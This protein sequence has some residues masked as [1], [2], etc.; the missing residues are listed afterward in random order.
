MRS[1]PAQAGEPVPWVLHGRRGGVY[2]RAGGGTQL[3]WTTHTRGSG[4]SPRRRGNRDVDPC[5]CGDQGS[6]PAQAGEPAALFG[7]THEYGVYP[8]AGGGTETIGRDVFGK[9][10]LSPRRRGNPFPISSRRFAMGSIPAQ[11]G[12]PSVNM[13]RCLPIRVYPRAGGGTKG[14]DKRLDPLPGLSPRRRGNH[15]NRKTS[16]GRVR[17]I[18]AQAGEPRR[19]VMVWGQ[20]GVYPRAGG[21]TVLCGFLRDPRAGLSPRR[22][23]NPTRDAGRRAVHGSIPAQAGE[24]R[25]SPWL[26]RLLRVYPRAGGGTAMPRS[27]SPSKAW[28][29]PAQAGEPPTWR[30][31]LES[32]AVY[33]R[34]GGGTA[35]CH[36]RAGCRSGLS[37]RRRG[38]HERRNHV[39]GRRG[40][41]PAQAGEPVS[42]LL[43]RPAARV[44][45][46]AG[47]GTAPP[48]THRRPSQGLSPRRRGNRT[49]CK[50]RWK[51]V[52]SIPAQAGEPDSRPRS[53]CL[54][55]VYP[56]AGGGTILDPRI[57]AA[58]SGLSPRRRGNP[59]L[60]SR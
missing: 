15:S 36:P 12:E 30:A 7:G 51:G 32:S 31:H 24:P 38:N 56:R 53:A 54:S 20:P 43:A 33:P 55:K 17:S 6:I 42:A 45:P 29:I 49:G 58:I 27:R 2:P 37:P 18:P 19:P 35:A 41:I 50:P 22:R 16:R 28:S 60:S 44:Y 5:P 11:A 34:A 57:S 46:R 26:L 3:T 14:R 59:L 8:R 1:I 9:Q 39:V 25:R 13:P 23:G 52:G 40:S 48:Q 47:G 4:L 10:G 21:G